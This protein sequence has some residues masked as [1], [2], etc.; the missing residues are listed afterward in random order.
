[1][2]LTETNLPGGGDESAIGCSCSMLQLSNS[3]SQSE[4]SDGE[5]LR[6]FEPCSASFR[7]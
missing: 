1:M 5:L 4:A 6:G 7:T 3:S 2:V